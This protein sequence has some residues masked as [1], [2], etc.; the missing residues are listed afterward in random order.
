MQKG[1]TQGY[2]G[3]PEIYSDK[4]GVASQTCQTNQP[5]PPET[6]P[7]IT[8]NVCTGEYV[9]TYDP[10]NPPSQPY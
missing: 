3:G 6:W 1:S 5:C 2:N 8:F 10:L 7:Y 4:L 9:D